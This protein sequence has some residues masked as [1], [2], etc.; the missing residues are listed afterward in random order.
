[1]P[2]PIPRP[3]AISREHVGDAR[4]ERVQEDLRKTTE[5]LNATL[6]VLSVCPFAV[7]RMISVR[8]VANTGLTVR[9]NLGTQATFIL[10]RPNYNGNGTASTV[11]ESSAALQQGL[12]KNNQLSVY[13]TASGVFDL[14]FYPVA[15]RAID[16]ATGQSTVP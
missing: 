7:G 3:V 2:S 14:W 9:H 16:N 5:A 4:L 12:D 11:Q 6:A 1:M 10:A 15:S 8:L 13:A